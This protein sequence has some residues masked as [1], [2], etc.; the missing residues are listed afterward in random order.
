MVA[1]ARRVGT[2]QARG[3]RGEGA[4]ADHEPQRL[5]ARHPLQR[6]QVRG[7]GHLQKS[8][9]RGRR[10]GCKA[11]FDEKALVCDDACNGHYCIIASETGMADHDIVDTY[12]GLWRLAMTSAT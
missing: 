3:R 7:E 6:R 11:R 5:L 12:R 8:D 4:P 2:T 9:R 10:S 1:Q